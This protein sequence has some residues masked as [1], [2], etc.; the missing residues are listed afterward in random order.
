[1]IKRIQFIV[2]FFLF[3]CSGVL[4]TYKSFG[5]VYTFSQHKAPF[6]ELTTFTSLDPASV[7]DSF[8]MV[9]IGFGFK[10]QD[11]TYTSLFVIDGLVTFL[12]T[13]RGRYDVFVFETELIDINPILPGASKVNY[14]TIGEAGE[15]IFILEWNNAGIAPDDNL[16]GFIKFQLWLYEKSSAIEIHYGPNILNPGQ[17]SLAGIGF[18]KVHTTREGINIYGTP[19]GLRINNRWFADPNPMEG[20]PKDSTV[21]RFSYGNDLVWNNLLSRHTEL[22]VGWGLINGINNNSGRLTTGLLVPELGGALLGH[23]KYKDVEFGEKYFLSEDAL[24]KG[25]VTQNYGAVHSNDSATFS[26]YTV[27]SN[28]LPG[29]LLQQKKKPYR[30]LDL[31]GNLNFIAFD[32]PVQVTDS[33]FVAFGLSP[34]QQVHLDT[35]GLYFTAADSSL[36]ENKQFGKVV[37]RWFNNQWYD[38]LNTRMLS[39]RTEVVLIE[40][41]YGIVNETINLSVFPVVNFNLDSLNKIQENLNCKP[42]AQ[43]KDKGLRIQESFIEHNNLKLHPNFPNP[44]KSHTYLNFTLKTNSSVTIQIYNSAGV[45]VL[46]EKKGVL[47]SGFQQLYI[48]TDALTNGVYLYVVRSDNALLSSKIVVNK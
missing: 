39:N 30:C 16:I 44:A 5:Q 32:N 20:I 6:K 21:Y 18:W 26:V 42:L 24:V 17:T 22:S 8:E 36:P 25:L 45:L 41:R 14:T 7:Y 13:S 11:K 43:R 47:N 34:Y 29:N 1:M 4:L 10:I 33:F 2:L 31:E 19:D 9:D 40:D 35:I 48:N 46:E 23:N 12:P 38:V 3:F 15:R 28:G 27:A 37:A